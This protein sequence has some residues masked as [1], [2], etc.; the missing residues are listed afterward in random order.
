VVYS[1]PN[2]LLHT[3]T[4][5]VDVSSWIQ[6]GRL[7]GL[8]QVY[9]TGVHNAVYAVVGVYGN[10]LFNESYVN[11]AG[12]PLPFKHLKSSGQVTDNYTW[13][14][15]LKF[16]DTVL[17]IICTNTNSRYDKSARYKFKDLHLLHICNEYDYM[18]LSAESKIHH[19]KMKTWKVK[20]KLSLYPPW[21]DRVEWR[22][23]SSHSQPRP[24][25]RWV[26]SLT[27]RPL[28]PDGRTRVT[29]YEDKWAPERV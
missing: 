7:L 3:R 20:L 25:W 8:Y 9:L 26:L 21:S 18:S 1:R 17:C 14:V 11:N 5:S 22:Y 13:K 6:C 23:I 15:I 10:R 4:W 24:R 27:S 2:S 16:T 19:N 28:H 12:R 29:E